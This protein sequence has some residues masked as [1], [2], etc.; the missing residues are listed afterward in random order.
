MKTSRVLT[1]LAMQKK[2]KKKKVNQD[3]TTKSNL[4]SQIQTVV[5]TPHH[6]PVVTC[7]ELA[8]GKKKNKKIMLKF[9]DSNALLSGAS[10]Y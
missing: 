3:V 8:V 9:H 4:F 7:D 10:W 5:Q 6:V 2:K 1:E